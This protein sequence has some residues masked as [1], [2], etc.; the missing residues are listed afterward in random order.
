MEY[1]IATVKNFCDVLEQLNSSEP[2]INIRAIKAAE[3]IK[4]TL[5][6]FR[7]KIRKEGFRSTED[8]IHFFKYVKPRINSYLIF[9]SVLAEIETSKITL[10]V[11]ELKLFIDK[12]ERKFRRVM[13][14]NIDFVQYYNAGLCHLDK[15]YFVR[16]A[17]FIWMTKNS[18]HQLTDPEFNVSHD[19]V[20][21]NILAFDLYKKHL[22]PKPELQATYG[23]PAPK[24]K[25]TASKSD[26]IE[27]VYAL[28]ATT[29]I[30]YGEN[31][32]KEI[33]T[34]LQSVFQVHIED[35]YRIFIDLANRKT[36]PLKFIPK[37]EEGFLRKVDE[38]EGMR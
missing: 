33:C 9:Y 15:I 10:N 30:N 6:N 35:P 29:A 19:L 16:E 11:E 8:E 21:A 12:K 14:E 7:T 36:A 38:I 28:Q 32:I 37:L 1:Y 27:L 5:E 25:W 23:P 13:R 26:F 31:E 20:A 17:N 2:D 24:L 3:L 34:A 4:N 22:S 18:A